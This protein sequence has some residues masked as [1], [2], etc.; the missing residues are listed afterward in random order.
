MRVIEILT[1]RPGMKLR[2][3]DERGGLAR[4]PQSI[5]RKV[6]GLQNK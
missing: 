3:R 4:D 5:K 6:Y 2:A 1:V